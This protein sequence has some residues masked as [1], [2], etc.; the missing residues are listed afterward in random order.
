MGVVPAVGPARKVRRLGPGSVVL[1]TVL[2]LALA[3]GFTG[4]ALAAYRSGPAQAALPAAPSAGPAGPEPMVTHT[5]R[6]EL[7]GD[8][9]RDITYVTQGSGIAQVAQASTPWSVSFEHRA[10]ARS[11][12][13]YSLSARAAGRGML[14]CRILVDGAVV[15]ERSVSDSDGIIHCSKTA[16]R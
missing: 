1:T 5:V 10:A 9:A 14:T 6:Y 11:S 3:G 2:G 4:A 7:T 8:F 15:S 13:Y 16:D 12:R